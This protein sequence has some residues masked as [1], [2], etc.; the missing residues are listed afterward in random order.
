MA[1]PKTPPLSLRVKPELRAR[2]EALAQSSGIRANALVVGWIEAGLA[3]DTPEPKKP[4][5]AAP[6]AVLAQAEAKAAHLA[7]PKRARWNLKGVQVGPT[8]PPM[9][10]RL[11]VKR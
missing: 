9:G 7:A 10:S 3:A 4:C 2:I 11:K 6:K 1:Q 8:A 5:K